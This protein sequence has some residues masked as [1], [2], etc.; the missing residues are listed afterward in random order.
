MKIEKVPNQQKEKNN[1]EYKGKNEY[2]E[3]EELNEL[4]KNDLKLEEDE[5]NRKKEI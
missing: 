3:K 5:E 4:L 2:F 1:L